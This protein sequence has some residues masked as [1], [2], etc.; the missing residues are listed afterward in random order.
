MLYNTILSK[1]ILIAV[2]I[3]RLSLNNGDKSH[4]LTTQVQWERVSKFELQTM[5]AM[6]KWRK[7]RIKEERKGLYK[8]VMGARNM[9][10]WED[11]L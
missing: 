5:V 1:G 8:R 6:V 10:R 3:P 9:R 2:I 11:E 7:M 4:W